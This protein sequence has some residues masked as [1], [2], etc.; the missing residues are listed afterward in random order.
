M[1]SLVPVLPL[2]SHG[3]THCGTTGCVMYVWLHAIV[4][5]V[6]L[7]RLMPPPTFRDTEDHQ[8]SPWYILFQPAAHVGRMALKISSVHGQTIIC[9]NIYSPFFR[10]DGSCQYFHGKTRSWWPVCFKQHIFSF[11]RIPHPLHL[12]FVFHWNRHYK[13]LNWMILSLPPG[14]TFY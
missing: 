13:W 3:V 4:Q 6:G 10:N 8:Q 2:W 14:D 12:I 1:S 5:L 7:V 11:A 9:V